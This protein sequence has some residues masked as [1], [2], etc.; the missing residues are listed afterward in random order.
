MWNEMLEFLFPRECH[1]CG[2]RL[3]PVERELCRH[4]VMELPRTHYH[5]RELNP[6]EERFAG[7][8]PFERGT[9]FLFY[10]RYSEVA[11]IIHDFKYRRFPGLA[12]EMGRI[13]GQ[14]LRQVGFFDGMD[15]VQPVP[16]HWF[17]RG[18]RGYNQSERVAKGVCLE[19]GLTLADT[20]RMPRHHNSQTR[21]NATER[22][23][24][25]S[26]RFSLVDIDSLKG[27]GVVLLD[28]VCTTGATLRAAGS[29]LANV[30]GIRI[31][32][33]SLACTY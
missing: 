15:M 4:C 16:M 24:N 27:K 17:K 2:C 26:G 5:D 10:S 14:E 31:R 22:E 11:H 23:R 30:P 1:I 19:T 12:V 18:V 33:L 29:L 9:A 13:M 32:I 6:F 8:F 7:I 21:L 20:L 3:M 25:I 28:D